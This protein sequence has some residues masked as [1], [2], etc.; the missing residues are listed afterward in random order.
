MNLYSLSSNAHYLNRGVDMRTRVGLPLRG[1]I[2][3]GESLASDSTGT[4]SRSLIKP[5]QEVAWGTPEPSEPILSH[6]KAEVYN[7]Q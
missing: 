6:G 2:Q 5:K 1:P 7:S 3:R 4:R